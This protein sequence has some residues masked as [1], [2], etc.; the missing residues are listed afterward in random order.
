MKL[1]TH[2]SYVLFKADVDILEKHFILK[3]TKSETKTSLL[4]IDI[5]RRCF[6]PRKNGHQ[7]TGGLFLF[8]SFVTVYIYP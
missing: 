1:Y 7:V 3:V 6:N 2:R 4:L 5:F 8:V